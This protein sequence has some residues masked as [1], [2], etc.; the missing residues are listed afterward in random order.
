[1]T[2]T[3]A[4]IDSDLLG[5][6]ANRAEHPGAN[7]EGLGFGLRLVRA[8]AEAHGGG[9]MVGSS[10]SGAS[11]CFS[12]GLERSAE[13]KVV[14]SPAERFDYTGGLDHAHVEFAGVMDDEYYDTRAI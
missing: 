10:E 14:N 7:A 11:V 1:M 5:V 4:G 13:D 9:L 8:I 12:I 6:I 3:G 2:D